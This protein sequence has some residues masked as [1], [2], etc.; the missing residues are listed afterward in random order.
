M[1]QV[2]GQTQAVQLSTH[3]SGG[4]KPCG[5]VGLAQFVGYVHQL[6]SDQDR[7]SVLICHL[8][9]EHVPDGDQELSG[10]GDDGLVASQA[11]FE[12]S[13][14]GLP[15]RVGIGGGLGSFDQG[16]AQVFASGLGD[17]PGTGGQAGVVHSP[18]QAGVTH[19]V[20]SIWEAGDIANGG[21]DM[22]VRRRMHIWQ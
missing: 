21:Q 10:D 16:R 12:A 4:R 19:Q 8:E 14:L 22:F 9:G 20:F 18:A 3:Q 15:V 1:G 2:L 13:Q 7:L 5:T 17:A 11:G 6:A